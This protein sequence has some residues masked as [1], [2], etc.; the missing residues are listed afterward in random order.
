MLDDDLP[1][2]RVDVERA[3]RALDRL[4]AAHPRADVMADRLERAVTVRAIAPDV[5]VQHSRWCNTAGSWAAGVEPAHD[6]AEAMY[7]FIPERLVAGDGRPDA[8]M[9]QRL[10]EYE[11]RFREKPERTV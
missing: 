5:F 9:R 6:A 3:L 2:Q 7:G 1:L 10:E 4:R 11:R 8:E